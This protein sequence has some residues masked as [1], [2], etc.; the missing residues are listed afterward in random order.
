[1]TSFV[2]FKSKHQ[3]IIIIIIGILYYTDMD[4]IFLKYCYYMAVTSQAL[5][6]PLNIV[7][8]AFEMARSNSE[9]TGIINPA[10][11]KGR[12][13]FDAKLSLR[14]AGIAQSV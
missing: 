1:M 9:V 8:N 3:I 4:F 10:N 5:V 2:T 7:R 14:G 11:A 13:K 6:K 12:F